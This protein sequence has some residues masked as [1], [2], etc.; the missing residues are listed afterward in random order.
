M[1]KKK[2]SRFLLE[3]IAARIIGVKMPPYWLQFVNRFG[4]GNVGT[5]HSLA[6]IDTSTFDGVDLENPLAKIDSDDFSSIQEMGDD[7]LA[8]WVRSNALGVPMQMPMSLRADDGEEWLLPYE[9]LVSLT[10]KNIITRRQVAKGK[11]R[12]SIKERW[13]QDDYSIKIDGIFIG[14][15]GYPMEEVNKL[16]K[17]CEAGQVEVY[18]PLLDFFGIT[19]MVV[20]SWDIPMTTGL[21]NQNY[22]LSCYSDETYKLLLTKKD[23]K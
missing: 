12:G 22:S 23:M 3:N 15:D 1:N 13:A 10:G 11:T 14:R 8:D 7:E 20:E 2:I 19:R 5:V 21:H 4:G 9:P 17:V 16:R 6:K 18:T